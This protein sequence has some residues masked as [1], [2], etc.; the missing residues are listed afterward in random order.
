MGRTVSDHPHGGRAGGPT[1]WNMPE[2][3]RSKNYAYLRRTWGFM[4]PY[5]LKLITA[6]L[7]LILTS[8]ATLSI[9]VGLKFL[10]DRGLSAGDQEFLNLG[11]LVLVAIILAISGGGRARGCRGAPR[12]V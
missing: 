12:G 8:A 10:I 5:T 6:G 2:R 11:F 7:A 3:P 4:K 9:G 1:R